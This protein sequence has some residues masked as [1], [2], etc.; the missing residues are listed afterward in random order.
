LKQKTKFFVVEQVC[1]N[2]SEALDK[3]DALY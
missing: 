3:Q 2:L 1:Q